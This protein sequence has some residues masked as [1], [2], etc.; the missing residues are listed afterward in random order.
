[1]KVHKGVAYFPTFEKAR[2]FGA[3]YGQGYPA[4]RAVPYELGWAV[5]VRPGGPYF[6]PKGDVV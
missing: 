1:M 2:D 4:W 3:R 5:Q 6:G